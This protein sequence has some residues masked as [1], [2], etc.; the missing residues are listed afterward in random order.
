ML[1]SSSF[2]GGDVKT[3][4]RVAL[5]QPGVPP[6]RQATDLA[7]ALASYEKGQR[8]PGES[9]RKAALEVRA[10]GRGGRRG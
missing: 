7:V 3:A 4:V 10:R 5:T 9:S 8:D 6:P 1:W 2:R